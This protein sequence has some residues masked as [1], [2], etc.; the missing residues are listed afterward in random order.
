MS[1]EA[2]PS[3][4]DPANLPEYVS[5]ELRRLGQVLRD[6][7]PRVFYRTSPGNQGSLSAAVSANFKI[8]AGNVVR[9]SSSATVTLTGLVNTAPNR[10]L[11]LVNVGHGVVYLKSE[12][13][14]SSASHRFALA[15]HWD[16]SQNAAATLWYD[17]AS[18]RWRGL[19]RT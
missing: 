4:I 5:R 19:S 6:N 11:V 13:T 9:I 17:A 1:Y 12:G 16:L 15:T 3:P 10:E 14:E 18:A 2:A 8:A 7:A